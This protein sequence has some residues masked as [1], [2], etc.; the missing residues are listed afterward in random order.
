[1]GYRKTLPK[2][3]DK[4]EAEFKHFV[5]HGKTC[6]QCLKASPNSHRC[7]ACHTAQYCSE[8]CRLKDLVWHKTVC[9][10]WA[11]DKTKKMPGRKEQKTEF[12]NLLKERR[13]DD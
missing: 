9:E 13:R 10:K 7:Y 1:M 4:E 12:K 5:K 8:E 3:G 2:W 6:D 11:K